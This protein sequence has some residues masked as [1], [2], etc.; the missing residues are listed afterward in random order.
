M[1]SQVKESLNEMDLLDVTLDSFLAP[2]ITMLKM[3]L[4][5]EISDPATV[6]QIV[7]IACKLSKDR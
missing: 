3:M 6:D 1:S 2:G 4:L 5:D 7:H